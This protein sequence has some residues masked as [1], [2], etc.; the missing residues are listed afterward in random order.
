MNDFYNNL[1]F[2]FQRLNWMSAVDILIVTGIFF[3][4]MMLI[5][6]TQAVSLMR[7][8]LLVIILLSLM[9]TFVDLPAF[10]W[11]V[12]TSLPALLLSVPVV[13]APELRRALER[14]GRAGGVAFNRSSTPSSLAMQGTI[15]AV[16][17]ACGRLAQRQHGA[18]IILQRG[19]TLEEYIKTGVKMESAVTAEVLLQIFYPNTPL[20][21]GAVIITRDQISCAASVMPLSASGILNRTPDRQMGLRHRAAL[22]IS[23]VSDAIAVV[24]SEETGSIS[25]AHGGRMIRKLDGERL[26][27]IL[28][29]FYHSPADDQFSWQ[30][31]WKKTGSFFTINQVNVKNFFSILREIIKSIPTLFL[32]L[33]L[34]SV[35][36]VAAVVQAD[37][38]EEKVYPNTVKIETIGQDP[39]LVITNQISDEISISLNAPQSIWQKLIREDNSVRAVV[40]LSGLGAGTYD[41]PVQIKIDTK[42]VK[43]ASYT[44]ETVTVNLEKIVTH[45]F[46]IHLVQTGE[47]AVGFTA[48]DPTADIKEAT[49]TGPESIVNKVKEIKATINVNG[50]NKSMT[51]SVNLQALDENKNVI[52]N[53]TVN[54]TDVTVTQE[55]TQKGGF[56][57]VVVRVNL[58]GQV[59]SG[60]RVTNISVYPPIITVY[61]SAPQ[62]VNDLPG[63]V[64]TSEIILSGSKEDLDERVAINLPAG[65]T[66]V[67]EQFVQVHISV[68]S[69]ESSITLS[70]MPVE[71][72]GLPN[73]LEA[74][75]SPAT[76]DVIIS[77]PIPLLDKLTAKD[78]RV[79][80]NMSNASV[81]IS[82]HEPVVEIKIE[83]LKVQSILP[84]NVELT[85]SEKGVSTKTPQVIIEATST[86]MP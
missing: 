2:L 51:Q 1:F 77:G 46:D 64:D 80:V 69:I 49:I 17:A 70:N 61:S 13:F 42:P 41:V 14:V 55:I 47:P 56:R 72:V 15:K 83:D 10:S 84:G 57:N 8:L 4:I 6:N 32:A 36:W 22:G 82:Q 27:N 33:V 16:V 66:V 60:Y 21:D 39:N 34:A 78:V 9:T 68:A 35:V 59:A 65:I 44:P 81:G 28:L 58:K 25:V 50:I 38:S 48:H 31:F 63:Y 75:I 24:V 18:L 86:P 67:G 45:K 79:L 37:P 53:A 85:I 11:L 12:R 3:V 71:V 23:E 7:G 30:D 52:D 20:H 43:V 54:P 76:V 40:D 19:D 29:A 5:R 26:E 73:D 62:R 74:S